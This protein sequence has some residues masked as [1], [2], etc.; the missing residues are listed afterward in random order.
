LALSLTISNVLSAEVGIFNNFLLNDAWTFA[1]IAQRHPGWRGRVKRFLKFNLIC[2]AG[3]VL[4]TVIL[5]LLVKE[6]GFNAYIAKFLAI[7]IVSIWNFV[8]NFSLNWRESK[9][10]E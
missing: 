8:L 5:N 2:L 7:A 6:L 1:D 10:R 9:I 4:N 3:L